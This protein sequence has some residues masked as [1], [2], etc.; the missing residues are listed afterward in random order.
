MNSEGLRASEAVTSKAVRRGWDITGAKNYVLTVLK[1]VGPASGEFLTDACKAAGFVPH[2]DR[3]FGQVYYGLKKI[4]AIEVVGQG[5][6]TKGR[7][8]SGL[9]IW[10]L[11]GLNG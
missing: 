6:R 10:A 2:D 3:A 5:T 4:G 7:G 1:Q 9:N 11:K 8:T